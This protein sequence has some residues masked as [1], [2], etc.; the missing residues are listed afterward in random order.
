[1]QIFYAPDINGISYTLDEKES[2]HLIRVLRMVKGSCVK[3]ID[4][5][6][7]LF[8]G[9]ISEPDQNKCI[10]EITREIKDFEKR[11]M[12]KII[13]KKP[14]EV[15]REEEQLNSRARSAKLRVFEKN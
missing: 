15:S 12:G 8:E 3:L 9:F 1:M 4:G 6:G 7:N 10:I 5:K 14:I 2:K 11:N 13:T